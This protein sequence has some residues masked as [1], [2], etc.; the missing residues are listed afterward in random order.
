M[1]IGRMILLG[2]ALLAGGGA[3]FLVSM[4]TD[5]SQTEVITQVIPQAE[6]TETVRVLVADTDFSK[7]QKMDPAA[8]KWVKFPKEN[9][10]EYFVT[11]DNGAF[12]DTLGETLAR[13]NI[14]LGEPIT[15]A[16][17]VRPGDASMMAALLTPGMRAVTLDISPKTSAAGFVLPGDRVDVYFTAEVKD[18]EDGEVHSELLYPNLRVLAIDQ[19]YSDTSE[20]AVIGRTATVEIAPYQVEDFLSVRES[21]DAVSLVLRSAFV[22]EGGEAIE[23]E[24]RPTEV[25]VIRYGRS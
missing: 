13:T 15:E 14:Y 10:P 17:I 19:V 23:Q 6:R 18:S 25:Q 9:L 12:F 16:K 2:V 5:G 21:A 11:E 8:V 7:G 24:V 1:N 22:P 4:G 20:G 3:F